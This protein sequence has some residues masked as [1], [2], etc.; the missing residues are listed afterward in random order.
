MQF[1]MKE[2]PSAFKGHLSELQ[3]WL[4]RSYRDSNINWENNLRLS[5]SVVEHI[6]ELFV[7]I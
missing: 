7:S 2:N 5:L 6:P 1:V 4:E 3:K